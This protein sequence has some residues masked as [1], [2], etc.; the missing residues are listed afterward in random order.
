MSRGRQPGTA[1]DR[2]RRLYRVDAGA[3]DLHDQGH[4]APAHRGDPEQRRVHRLRRAWRP[5][6]D[7]RASPAAAAA[8]R[9]AAA[10]VA[11]RYLKFL[12]SLLWMSVAATAAWPVAT[13][14]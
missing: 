1:H 2:D 9:G 13:L 4:A 12:T 6:A 5:R 14:S 7:L 11:A 3:H 8:Q 10:R